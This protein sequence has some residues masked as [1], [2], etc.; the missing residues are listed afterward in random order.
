MIHDGADFPAEFDF[1][2][3]GMEIG[4]T[5]DGSLKAGDPHTL[6]IYDWWHDSQQIMGLLSEDVMF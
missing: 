2:H 1:A 5:A 4:A 6:G 3:A